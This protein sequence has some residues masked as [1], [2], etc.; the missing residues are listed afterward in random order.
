M[1]TRSRKQ[2]S[3]TICGTGCVYLT[4]EARRW[5]ATL[6]SVGRI[7]YRLG[8]EI[9]LGGTSCTCPAQPAYDNRHPDSD[10]LAGMLGISKAFSIV[11][12]TLQ[13]SRRWIPA[14]TNNGRADSSAKH[15]LAF[16]LVL[17]WTGDSNLHTS[18]H[19][20]FSED[21]LDQSSTERHC[22][23]NSKRAADPHRYTRIR[24]VASPAN[25]QP[26]FEQQCCP[27]AFSD[28]ASAF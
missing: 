18:P 22:G 3:P 15:L 27:V 10:D 12:S 14:F 19:A 21:Q 20:G 23:R 25:Q 7:R 24:Q 11:E 17:W 5:L 1:L 13:I 28:I 2:S 8:S 9:P 16:W 4:C 6:I 26:N